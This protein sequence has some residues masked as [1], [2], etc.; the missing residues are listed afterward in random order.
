MKEVI[1]LGIFIFILN[2]PF[3]IWRSKTKKFSKKWFFAVHSPVP[4]IIATRLYFEIPLSLKSF[5]VFVFCYF[6]G[7]IIGARFFSLII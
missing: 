5:P 2:I 6:L 3:G 1:Y 7:Q 4:F